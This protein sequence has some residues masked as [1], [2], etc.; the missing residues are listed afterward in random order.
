MAF[1]AHPM[2][3]EPA[4]RWQV[5]L[6][7]LAPMA[8]AA[9]G[10]MVD[11]RASLGFTLW[12]DACRS[13][14]VTAGSLLSFTLTLL[15]NAVLGALLG[16]LVLLSVGASGCAGGRAAHVSLAA[17]SACLLGM[18]LGVLLCVTLLPAASMLVV[19]PLLVIAIAVLLSSVGPRTR[20]TPSA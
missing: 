11:E 6:L 10:A 2:R 15:P 8:L 3:I 9:A 4:A 12:L 18:G 7:A 1:G 5:P 20:T 17:H 16:G 13:A 19:E 14:G